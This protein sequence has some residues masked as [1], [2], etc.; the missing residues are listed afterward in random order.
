MPIRPHASREQPAAN[1]ASN[2]ASSVAGK[3]EPDLKL[4]DLDGKDVSLADYKGK[5]SS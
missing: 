1:P 4:K 3:P 5:S 2:P